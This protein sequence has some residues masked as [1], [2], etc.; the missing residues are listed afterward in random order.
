LVFASSAVAE[1]GTHLRPFLFYRERYKLYILYKL[2]L[3]LV[4]S[5]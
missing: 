5:I 1:A 3:N 2:V 4:D